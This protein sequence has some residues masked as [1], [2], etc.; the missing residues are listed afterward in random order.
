MI[1]NFKNQESIKEFLKR[2]KHKL[3]EG[4][5]VEELFMDDIALPSNWEMSKGW[6]AIRDPLNWSQYILFH[7]SSLHPAPTDL[8]VYHY[9]LKQAVCCYHVLL[10]DNKLYF[11]H[12]KE[13]MLITPFT[14]NMYIDEAAFLQTYGWHHP[15]G[16]LLKAADECRIEFN[17]GRAISFFE[18]Q[19]ILEEIALQR[20]F[21]N[22]FLSVYSNSFIINLDAFVIFKNELSVLEIKFKYP[23]KH[24]NYG[25][26]KG[27]A[28]LFQ[29]LMGLNISIYH[30]VADNPTAVK[31]FGIFDVV[32]S[33]ASRRNFYW[34]VKKLFYSEL[35]TNYS[36]APKETNIAGIEPVK[37][38]PIPECQFKNTQVQVGYNTD[39]TFISKRKCTR[40]GCTG[41]LEIK[42]GPYGFFFGC[43][44]YRKH[45][46]HK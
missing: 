30:Y 46:S 19:D 18:S 16:Q 1:L 8:K 44:D 6:W 35:N 33:S 41:S 29:W 38:I 39:F 4:M 12:L 5:V 7:V 42:N 28:A 2:D 37:F 25:I 32:I 3:L 17:Q 26:N 21:A 11:L 20:Y 10:H 13:E 24:G 15:T 14:L 40:Y 22:Y 45:K 43:N 9:L 34:K 23:D 27:Q 36:T 31:D